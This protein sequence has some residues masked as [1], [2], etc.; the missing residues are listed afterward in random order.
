MWVFLF[1]GWGGQGGGGIFLEGGKHA[2]PSSSSIFFFWEKGCG[3][4][5]FFVPKRVK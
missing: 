4:R 5:I 2:I 3:V 1:M